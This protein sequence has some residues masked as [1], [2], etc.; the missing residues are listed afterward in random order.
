MM[1]SLPFGVTATACGGAE[2]VCPLPSTTALGVGGDCDASRMARLSDGA[3]CGYVAFPSTRTNFPSCAET[4]RSAACADEPSAKPS[5]NSTLRNCSQTGH[6][7]RCWSGC[8]F[9]VNEG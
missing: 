2:I 8:Y 5:M 1:A 6:A 4:I 9:E 3:G 7:S